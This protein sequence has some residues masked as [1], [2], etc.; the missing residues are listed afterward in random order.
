MEG[1]KK[2][3]QVRKYTRVVLT[4]SVMKV[5]IV[6]EEVADGKGKAGHHIHGIFDS[7]VKA[8]DFRENLKKTDESGCLDVEA[9]EVQ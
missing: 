8:F 6:Y 5:W 4:S 9:F 7:E 1:G 3:I 2:G